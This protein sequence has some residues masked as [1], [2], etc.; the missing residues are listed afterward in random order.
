MHSSVV[1]L[2]R[3]HWI[4]YTSHRL[5]PQL[6][7]RSV[8]WSPV[9]KMW[10]MHSPRSMHEHSARS[11]EASRASNGTE[12]KSLRY[13]L[14]PL[15]FHEVADGE[16]V[17]LILALQ[18]ILT[19]DHVD[20]ITIYLDNQAVAQ[21]VGN[22]K[23]KASHYL[24][25]GLHR[26]ISAAHRKHKQLCLHIRWIPGHKDVVGNERAD[27]LAKDAASGNVSRTARFPEMLRR[28]LPRNLVSMRK[29]FKKETMGRVRHLWTLS[30]RYRR[31]RN[32]DAQCLRPM[33]Y[34][35]LIRPL[36]RMHSSILVQLRTQHAPLNVH[37]HRIKKIP[38]P[39]C[40]NCG[41]PSETVRHFLLRCPAYHNARSRLVNKLGREAYSLPPL[42]SKAR[43]IPAL[44]AFIRETGRLRNVF[45]N[46]PDVRQSPNTE[47]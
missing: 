1:H 11:Q 31:L 43:C 7:P 13:K 10:Q 21:A 25:D 12:L 26:L 28:S 8:P 19:L 22:R 35:K 23:P 24:Y 18:I 14:G 15:R 42:L 20:D 37:L 4:L 34:Q 33:G 16:A 39:A 32:V 40:P 3:P 47:S 44:M 2:L 41:H 17:G 27:A 36:S 46:I 30:A 29:T 45:A 5:G 6:Q 38:S 9:C